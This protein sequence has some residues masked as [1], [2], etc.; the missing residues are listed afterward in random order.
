MSRFRAATT[1]APCFVVCIACVRSFHNGFFGAAYSP[2][3]R[4]NRAIPIVADGHDS[5]LSCQLLSTAVCTRL[6]PNCV[7]VA[8]IA[9]IV[10]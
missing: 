8:V 6:S 2:G 5:R 1:D 4:V 9:A 7:L 10:F 3:G